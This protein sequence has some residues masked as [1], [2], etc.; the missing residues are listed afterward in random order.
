MGWVAA[1]SHGLAV[2][3]SLVG[4]YVAGWEAVVKA[5][6]VAAAKL[7]GYSGTPHLMNGGK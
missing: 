6:G 1:R 5:C 3:N 4:P 7:Q 2:V